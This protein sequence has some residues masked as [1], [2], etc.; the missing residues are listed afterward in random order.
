MADKVAVQF[1]TYHQFGVWEVSQLQRTEPSAFNGKVCVRRYR[2][3]V[4]EVGEPVDII[5][6]RIQELCWN[7]GNHRDSIAL[8]KV[9]RDYGMDSSEKALEFGRNLKEDEKMAKKRK[10]S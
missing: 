9:A 4:E 2:V 5:R 6:R 1:E 3:T 10:K 8:Q 7:C